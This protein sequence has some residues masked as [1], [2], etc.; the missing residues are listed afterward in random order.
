MAGKTD[1]NRRVQRSR[2]S[3]ALE[4]R[5]AW[6]IPHYHGLVRQ[7]GKLLQS[8]QG[9][10]HQPYI[11]RSPTLFPCGKI[12]HYKI[13]RYVLL[14]NDFPITISGKIQKFKMR[15]ESVKV[16]GLHEADRI[17]TA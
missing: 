17:E 5:T 1:P 10:N 15:E 14:V 2:S 6:L 8:V 3:P 9:Y 7:T 11:I 13:P 12:A 16:L 4:E